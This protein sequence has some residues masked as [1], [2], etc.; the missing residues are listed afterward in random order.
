MHCNSAPC[1][2]CINNPS[3]SN[4]FQIKK[5]TFEEWIKTNDYELKMVK[6]DKYDRARSIWNAAQEN[7]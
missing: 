3:Y 7:K 1:I 5:L 6:N 4:F 2:K